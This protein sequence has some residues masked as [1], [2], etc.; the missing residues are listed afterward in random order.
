MSV[1]TMTRPADL[2]QLTA[3]AER[4]SAEAQKASAVASAAMAAAQLAAE[5]IH[6]ER[7]HRFVRWAEGRLSESNATE[8]ALAGEV[9]TARKAFECAVAAGEPTFVAAY[10]GWA[11]AGAALYHARNHHNNL[12]GHLHHR[13]PDQHAAYDAGRSTNDSRTTIPSLADALGIAAAHAAAGR[14]G[15]VE[16]ALQRQLESALRGEVDDA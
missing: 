13:R 5:K 1:P 4:A 7:D 8:K 3:A 12:R 11:T 9:D 16:D 10:L 15:D 6:V 2:A 14:S